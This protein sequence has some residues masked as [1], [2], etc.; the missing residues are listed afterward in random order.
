[1]ASG[2]ATPLLPREDCAKAVL[3]GARDAV[4]QGGME[5]G[6]LGVCWCL[7]CSLAQAEAET[8]RVRS[9]LRVRL[10]SG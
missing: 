5:G 10:G 9:L 1:M 6:P 7:V 3:H 8:E 2:S 4:S